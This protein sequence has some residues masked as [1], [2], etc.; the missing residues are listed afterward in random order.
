MKKIILSLVVALLGIGSASATKLYATYGTPASE[1][2]WNAET[3][4]YTWTAS[5]SNLMTIFSFGSG[6]LANYTSLHLTT[7]DYT[8]TYRVCFMNGSTAVATIAFYSAGQKDLVFAERNET[9]DL[10]LSAITHISFGGASGSGSI[11]L[12][13]TPYMVKPTTVDFDETGVAI[14]GLTDITADS[15]LTYDDQTG[16]MTSNGQ[17]TFSVSLNNEDFSSVTKV[18]LLRSGDDIVQTLQ[19]K[20]ADNGVLNTWYGSKYSCD[21]TSYQAKAGKI[22]QLS[23]NCNTA[24]TMTI[25][26][27]RLTA[28]VI[29][30]TNPHY[31]TFTK[32]MF[33][34]WTGV[35]G[36]AEQTSETVY[37]SFELNTAL[38]AGST[39]V[40]DG[41]VSNLFYADLSDYDK[42]V[43]E[44]TAG[45][46]LRVLL[47]RQAD[48]SLTELNPTFDS[49]GKFEIDLSAYKTTPGYVH[50]NAIKRPWDGGTATI[51]SILLYKETVSSPYDYVFAGSGV[52]TASAT[53]ALADV[54]ATSFDATGITKATALDAANPNS[55]F[56]ANTGMLTNAS[57]VIVSGA[58]ANFSLT[59]GY[60]LNVPAAFTAT[61]AS[62]ARTLP[63]WSTSV[64]PYDCDVPEG[65]TAYSVSA[66]AGDEY[67]TCT[68]LSQITANEPFLIKAD[69]NTDATFTASEVSVPATPNDL[70][71]EG[72]TGVFKS[73]L[74]PVGSYVLQSGEFKKVAEGSQP[75]IHP[76][77]AYLTLSSSAPVL[78]V[79][80]SED[81]ETAIGRLAVEGEMKEGK[82]FNLQGQEVAAPQRGQVYVQN[83][84]R[85][86]LK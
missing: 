10:D 5:Y 65:V 41:N 42:L 63:A 81:S 4:T 51:T 75:T 14:I 9:K 7:S 20:D 24:G 32:G 1:G 62:Y 82:I 84:R 34:K 83:G 46:S 31:T 35:D 22:T 6:E 18:E 61:S 8:G 67:V 39:V 48:N 43:V 85:F 78:R 73:Q 76:F 40:G 13:A 47:N 37:P 26:G 30:A 69:A 53:A 17:G 71:N 16:E 49:N 15:N 60:A 25:T 72:L 56:A 64:L 79:V 23:W 33:H 21:F 19:I 70:G 38:A 36:S 68:K 3:N 27:I 86:I 52:L 58:C 44:G 28:S 80:F 55:L 77:R 29:Y 54:S 12:S 50:L 66:S 59:D 57:N 2:S 45:T 11:T 74:A